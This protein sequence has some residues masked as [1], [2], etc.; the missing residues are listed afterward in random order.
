L[1]KAHEASTIA[2]AEDEKKILHWQGELNSLSAHLLKLK[3]DRDEELK[4]L[5]EGQRYIDEE[6][7]AE[8]EK[9]SAI[10]DRDAAVAAFG[11]QLAQ[12]QGLIALFAPVLMRVSQTLEPLKESGTIPAT[13]ISLLP[14]LLEKGECVCGLK[15]ADH[16]EASLKLKLIIKNSGD[17][18]A[19]AS[20]ADS[21]L[22]YARESFNRSIGIG[23]TD[24][25]GELTALRLEI[26]KKN[27]IIALALDNFEAA[28]E[29]RKKFSNNGPKSLQDRIKNY[30][31]ID[32][33]CREAAEE[34]RRARDAKAIHEQD[35]RST[36]AKLQNAEGQSKQLKR[37]QALN[38]VA[39]TLAEVINSARL[40]IESS[41]VES[42]D[43][44]IDFLF[45]DI[46]GAKVEGHYRHVGI[47][48]V[49]GS[50]REF[51]PYITGEE[52]RDKPIGSVN[53]ASRRAVAISLLL[54]I[55]RVT[56]TSIPFVADSLLHS[57]S[58]E[59]TF[60]LLKYL[61]DSSSVGQPILFV[62]RSDLLGAR[63]KDLALERAGRTYT[64]TSEAEVGGNVVHRDPNSSHSLESVICLCRPDECCPICERSEDQ[65]DNL[66]VIRKE[67][68]R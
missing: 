40:N 48:R 65:S 39:K 10:A 6:R 51:E 20:F 11:N 34:L 2:V 47:R 50:E 61:T 35:L 64:I 57:T 46:I 23:A 45:K 68:N 62:T 58:G 49:P 53:G 21:C 16:P 8:L 4:R 59:V 42:L 5:G 22:D 60:S 24:W 56:G 38:A 44:T 27:K 31:V 19:R 30:D 29:A 33:Q 41:Q 12:E 37:A 25:G 26:A 9:N 36:A 3:T 17:A 18:K 13:E 63:V 54:G 67:I 28:E 43:A 66:L 52:G 1:S 7:K 14:R 15:F 55:S 32:G